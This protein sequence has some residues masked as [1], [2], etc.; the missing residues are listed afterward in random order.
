MSGLIAKDLT[1]L[2]YYADNGM[3]ERYWN[4][5]AN[6]TTNDKPDSD[7]YGALALTVVRNDAM[8]GKVANNYAQNYVESHPI[9]GVNILNERQWEKVGV[10]LIRADLAERQKLYPTHP[11]LA[12]N[13]PVEKVYHSHINAFNKN[14]IDPKAW[15]PAL[16]ID[17]SHK[18]TGNMTQANEIWRDM[19]V[20][21]NLGTSR[22]VNALIAADTNDVLLKPYTA[23]QI[24]AW[25]EATRDIPNNDLNTIRTTEKNSVGQ[26]ENHWYGKV[27]G[28]WFE[29]HISNVGF[30]AI[31]YALPV[32][33]AKSQQLDS[34]SEFRKQR[35]ELSSQE[36]SHKLDD[37]KEIIKSQFTLADNQ[38]DLNSN[39]PAVDLN[40]SPAIQKVANQ[41]ELPT[42]MGPA[43]AHIGPEGGYQNHV[44]E[45]G[46]FGRVFNTDGTSY[47]YTFNSDFVP[48][49]QKHLD[50]NGTDVTPPNPYA[51]TSPQRDVSQE[52]SQPKISMSLG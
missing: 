4:Y 14:G 51:S 41:A 29:G 5:L 27:R 25:G 23:N 28:T 38:Q 48:I 50:A 21:R 52:Q 30:V 12:L 11:D 19:L 8:P 16:L 37:Y 3:R 42:L 1:V 31:P 9:G 33:Q 43:A 18:N 32:D 24:K 34:I 49:N 44:S 6:H 20:S 15:T 7:G 26:L 35:N 17:A 22:A 45:D 10:D 40:A 36:K 47:L 39:N 13:L 2:Q 46:K